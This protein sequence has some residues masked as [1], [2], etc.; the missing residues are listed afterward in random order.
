MKNGKGSGRRNSQ[1][2]AET[3]ENNWE[4]IFG[5]KTKKEN[6][7]LS[8]YFSDNGKKEAVVIKTNE[9]FMVELFEQSRYIRSVDCTKHSIHWAEDVAENWTMGYMV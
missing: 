6:R 4:K 9:G 1:I 3:F 8:K 5:M 2:D 7:E